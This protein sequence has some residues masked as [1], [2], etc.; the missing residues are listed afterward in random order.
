MNGCHRLDLWASQEGPDINSVCY[1]PACGFDSWSSCLSPDHRLV[2]WAH[3]CGRQYQCK[4]VVCTAGFTW[5]NTS[6]YH[7]WETQM[8]SSQHPAWLYKVKREHTLLGT[9]PM[10]NK[11]YGRKC[12]EKNFQNLP[13]GFLSDHVSPEVSRSQKRWPL[14]QSQSQQIKDFQRREAWIKSVITEEIK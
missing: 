2:P 12:V 8:G 10:G 3:T 14:L 1:Q 9:I 11:S 4:H 6:G 5:M 7:P 13:T